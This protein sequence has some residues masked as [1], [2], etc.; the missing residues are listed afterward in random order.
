MQQTLPGIETCQ[1]QCIIFLNVPLS[2]TPFFLANVQKLKVAV[3]VADRSSKKVVFTGLH[4]ERQEL[5]NKKRKL[6]VCPELCFSLPKFSR[7]RIQN[8]R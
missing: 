6:M 4:K 5:I 3:S 7:L 8:C 1:P 2:L